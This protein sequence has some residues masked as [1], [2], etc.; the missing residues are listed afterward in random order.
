RYPDPDRIPVAVAAISSSPATG[1]VPR[2]RR[3]ADRQRGE[4]TVVDPATHGDPALP[5]APGI[6]TIR[7]LRCLWTTDPAPACHGVAGD[8]RFADDQLRIRIRDSPT[9]C[10]AAL[11][12]IR[13]RF[14]A[15]G[16]VVADHA[17]RDR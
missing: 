2:N 10:S 8:R 9:G 3:F 15:G 17:L 14:L 5:S 12:P 1:N 11:H 4:Q 16:R 6:L 7:D 13:S